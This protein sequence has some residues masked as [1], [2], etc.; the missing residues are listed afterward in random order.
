MLNGRIP[1]QHVFLE[2]LTSFFRTLYM[3]VSLKTDAQNNPDLT[4]TCSDYFWSTPLPNS[5]IDDPCELPITPSEISQVLKKLSAGKATSLDNVSNEMLKLAGPLYLPFF[6]NLFNKIY[7]T[8][9]FPSVWKQA[10]LTTLHKKGAKQD[11]ANYCPLSITSCFGK[12]FTGALNECLIAFM[13]CKNIAHPFQGAFTRGRRGTDHIFLANTLIDQ[14]KFL[15]HPL[16][17]AFIDLQKAYDSVCRPLL[18]RKM[19]IAGLGPKFCTIVEDMYINASYRIKVGNKLG[20]SFST[21]IGLRQGDPLSPLLFNL[22]IAD[23]IF[24]S[25][26]VAPPYGPGTSGPISPICGRYLQFRYHPHPD[27]AITGQLLWYDPKPCYLGVCLSDIKAEQN[28]IMLQKASRAAYALRSMIDST[29]AATVTNTLFEQLIEP[30]L[31][32]AVEQWLPYIHPRKVDKSGPIDTFSALSSQLTTEDVWKKFIYPYYNLNESTP[33][34]A[35]R[36][37]FGSYPI[38]VA[39]I[40]RLAKYMSYISQEEAPPLVRKAV[41]TQKVMAS[42]KQIQLVV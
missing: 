28:S 3:N 8:A 4:F 32:Y 12:L 6:T 9:S 1:D 10:Y 34:L 22:F 33:V 16:Y 2:D 39:G 17:V 15:G 14:A 5:V 41:L 37:E 36:A 18:F 38:F 40:S 20:S 25:P 11:P 13:I 7:S 21:N 29:A 27:I 35:V 23:I 31:L 26:E 42:K 30:I 24:T 19:V